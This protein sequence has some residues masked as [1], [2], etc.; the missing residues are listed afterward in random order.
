MAEPG[1]PL[2]W[3]ALRGLWPALAIAVL[4]ALLGGYWLKVWL[5]AVVYALAASGVALLHAR[6]GLVHLGQVALMGMGGWV[7]LRLWHATGWPAE[8]C[9]LAAAAAGAAA[10]VLVGLPALWLRGLAFSVA[11]LMVAGGFAVWTAALQFPN[12]GGGGVSGY[13]FGTVPM[14][15]PLL[16]PSDAALLRCAAL[17]L[18][19]CLAL[20][21]VLLRGPAGRAWA[22]MRQSPDAAR[23]AGVAVRRRTLQA[24]AVAGAVAGLAGG[25]LATVLGTLDP[26]SFAAAEGIL[27][28]AVALIGGTASPLGVLLAGVL[29]RVLPALLDSAGLDAHLATALFGLGLLHA[30]ATAPLGLAGQAAQAGTVLRTALRMA[31]RRRAGPP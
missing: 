8:A 29:H 20:Q 3:R 5:A 30:L 6:L 1:P 12:G 15:R 7:A 25:L 4:P 16:A 10:G 23:M 26:R 19:A 9:L 11:T 13:G 21:Q 28:L 24:L 31:L 27:L 2:A 17:L 18:W 14:A 22:L